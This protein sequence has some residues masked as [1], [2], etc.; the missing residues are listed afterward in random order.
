MA[1]Y[2]E[3]SSEDLESRAYAIFGHTFLGS[4]KVKEGSL[5]QEEFKDYNVRKR[6]G[7][8]NVD[9]GSND[10][11]KFLLLNW[12]FLAI[13][14]GFIIQGGILLAIKLSF[15]NDFKAYHNQNFELLT[16]IE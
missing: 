7:E 6:Y 11:N 14:I 10:P 8:L 13:V 5:L 16:H 9:N 12:M 15:F 4:D 3:Q 1:S 2:T